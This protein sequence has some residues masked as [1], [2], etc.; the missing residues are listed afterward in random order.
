MWD[1][2]DLFKWKEVPCI[3]GRAATEDDIEKSIRLTY[4]DIGIDRP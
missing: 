1:E 2:I 4:I 3:S